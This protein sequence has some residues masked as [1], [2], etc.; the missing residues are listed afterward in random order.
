M[1]GLIRAVAS[2]GPPLSGWVYVSPVDMVL[3]IGG[4]DINTSNQAESRHR[5]EAS[6][7]NRFQGEMTVRVVGIEPGGLL[8]VEGTKTVNIDRTTEELL[9][10]GLVRPEDVSERNMVDSW[11]VGEVELVYTSSGTSPRGGI[12]GRILGAIW[13]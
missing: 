2:L 4:A 8:R 1:T 13:P 5:S 10:K 9:L 7:Q 6:R 3:P 12:I 11:R